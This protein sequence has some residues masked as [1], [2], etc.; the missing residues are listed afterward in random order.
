[1]QIAVN[2]S[3][4]IIVL[5]VALLIFS[6][7]SVSWEEGKRDW[8]KINNSVDKIFGNA[9]YNFI[10]FEIKQKNKFS[11]YYSIQ[12]NDITIAYLI[13]DKSPSKFHLFDYFVLCNTK[14]EIKK[15]TILNYRENYGGEICSKNW[16]KQ[17]ENNNTTSSLEFNNKVDGISGATISVNS[18]KNGV[19]FNTKSLKGF[20]GL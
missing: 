13:T 11:K 9:D 12:K 18:L 16:L 20:L 14:S 3:K 2:I 1:M 7:S 10:Q 15:V 6:F 5:I 19:W 8:K 4:A 17:F